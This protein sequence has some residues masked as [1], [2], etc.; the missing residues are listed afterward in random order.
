MHSYNWLNI[1]HLAGKIGYLRQI[2]SKSTIDT[3]FIHETKLDS[4]Y[5]DAQFE[6]PAFQYLPYNKD[7]NKNGGG[8]IVFI[9]EVLI[10]KR[11]KDFEGDI[12][13]TIC[14]EIMISEMVWFK[15]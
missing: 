13:E 10:T 14:R 1:N 11:L 8:K 4:F 3:L 15:T 2:Y 9:A 7:K 5:P 6:I 12:S